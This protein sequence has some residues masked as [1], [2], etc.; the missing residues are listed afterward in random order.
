M[1]GCLDQG[2]KTSTTSSS[3]TVPT[4]FSTTTTSTSP[5]PTTEEPYWMQY[6][7]N[8]NLSY[9][10]SSN[11][12]LNLSN[13][14]NL[15]SN[16]T[17][18]SAG[19]ETNVGDVTCFNASVCGESRIEYGCERE[20]VEIGQNIYEGELIKKYVYYPIC[21]YPGTNRSFCEYWGPV[22]SVEEKC[23][24]QKKVC[25]I[26]HN[27]CTTPADGNY[28]N[29]VQR[30][31]ELKCE[32]GNGKMEAENLGCWEECEPPDEENNEYC[33][34]DVEGCVGHRYW[35]RPDDRGRCSQR[36]TCDLDDKIY[37]CLKY[38]CDAECSNKGDCN[39]GN[40]ETVDKCSE[41]CMCE[42][43]LIKD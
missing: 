15:T 28:L 4:A 26:N 42:H 12:S 6:I 36:C 38:E 27:E 43:I 20:F 3:T 10:L 19:N 16:Q 31:Y 24:Q 30:R 1:T 29:F 14:S 11:T 23:W 33:P 5:T 40:P 13:T 22:V 7:R 25:D 18:T 21:R 2:V 32:C 34:Q 37:K 35:K 39:D 17:N 8:G 41:D 9:N